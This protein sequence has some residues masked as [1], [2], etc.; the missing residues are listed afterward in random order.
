MN[1]N[2][3]ICFEEDV[4]PNLISPCLC[5]GNI[6]YVHR[7]CLDNW[8]NIPS[9]NDKNFYSCEICKEEFIL[10]INDDFTDELN[11]KYKLCI[12]FEIFSIVF[13]LL[14]TIY[15]IGKIM[16][17]MSTTKISFT[18]NQIINEFICGLV[19]ILIICV[20][21]GYVT[22]IYS[23]RF[24]IY[25]NGANINNYLPNIKPFIAIIGIITLLIIIYFIII[26]FINI[27]K[28][29]FLNKEISNKYIVRDRDR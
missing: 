25:N 19:I 2:C 26:H 15:L 11:L 23:N 14:T 6:K 28:K 18:N 5:S 29:Y 17:N 13:I 4:Y 12:G 3:R 7:N 16:H 27:R 20:F 1:N 22:L 8:R 10:E 21:I 24:R 9:S